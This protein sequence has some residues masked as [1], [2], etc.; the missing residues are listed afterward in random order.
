MS[1]QNAWVIENHNSTSLAVFGTTINITTDQLNYERDTSPPTNNTT[2][3]QATTFL[4]AFAHQRVEWVIH[5]EG[6]PHNIH[7]MLAGTT[8][9]AWNPLAS[10]RFLRFRF[11]L[12]DFEWHVQTIYHKLAVLAPGTAGLVAYGFITDR[13]ILNAACHLVICHRDFYVTRVILPELIAPIP[14]PL[15]PLE[16]P[17]KND[18][19]IFSTSQTVLHFLRSCYKILAFL[20]SLSA[21]LASA[22]PVVDKK[23]FTAGLVLAIVGI[24]AAAISVIAAGLGWVLAWIEVQSAKLSSQW[25]QFHVS[26]AS[27]TSESLFTRIPAL[28]SAK[29]SVYSV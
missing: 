25:R 13:I 5:T 9:N 29:G 19:A 23:N 6:L 21:L 16:P 8:A 17:Y 1:S 2:T 26:F 3:P 15:E 22:Q 28:R 7:S 27:L 11:P 24:F 12:V 18:L 20:M 14:L 4:R 10:Y